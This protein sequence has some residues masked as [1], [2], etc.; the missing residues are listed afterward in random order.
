[1]DIVGVVGLVVGIAA[2]IVAI[3]GIRDVRDQVR[4][5]V[6]IERNSAY[7]RIL[8]RLV[9]EFVDPTE[10]ALSRDIA[11]AMQEFTLL[12]R[13]VN[14]KMTLN[15]AQAEANNETLTYAQMLVDGG[16]GTWKAEM[17]PGRAKAQLQKWQVDK[18]AV[19]MATIF[20]KRRGLSI[21]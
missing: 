9:W 3:Y 18:N 8:H 19:L 6:T 16:Y 17:D 13:A 5:L 20:G 11:Q 1:M 14:P 7:T 10:K 12:A 4:M 15:D 2:L 21:F